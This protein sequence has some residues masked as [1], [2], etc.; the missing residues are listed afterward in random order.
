V[1]R[2]FVSRALC[3]EV[4]SPLQEPDIDILLSK[5]NEHSYD[6]SYDSLVSFKNFSCKCKTLFLSLPI[7]VSALKVRGFKP[8]NNK[9][10]TKEEIK[11]AQQTRKV[12]IEE[13]I[14]EL[15]A[16]YMAG[17]I[18][19]W[20]EMQAKNNLVKPD[21]SGQSELLVNFIQW[22]QKE[23]EVQEVYE[24]YADEYLQEKLTNSH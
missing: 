24:M 15:K 14:D 10:F 2:K 20:N 19:M 18:N 6:L 4:V 22:L 12:I 13:N 3:T 5:P 7:R 1:H 16:I 21:V 11:T 23:Y 17:E 9:M 8:E